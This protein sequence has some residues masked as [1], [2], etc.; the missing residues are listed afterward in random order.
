M[1]T[2]NQLVPVQTWLNLETG[3][4]VHQTLAPAEA[5]PAECGFSLSSS[6]VERPVLKVRRLH[7]EA[8]VPSRANPTD[9]GLDL[10]AVEDVTLAPAITPKSLTWVTNEKWPEPWDDLE[11]TRAIVRT[12]IAVEF[13]PGLALLIWDRSGMGAKGIH[14]LAGV[15]DSAYR[16]ELK[17]VLV[18]HSP[19]PY[20][21][22]KGDRIA[23]AIIQPV[24]LPTVV[25][26]ENLSDS[27]RGV[28]GFGSTGA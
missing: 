25:E 20:T 6:S 26:V 24:I 9:A 23:Q 8:R 16:G 21:I 18:N 12:G 2:M 17:V 11:P 22:K 19:A 15:I 1:E 13:P 10:Y 28:A 14:R 3:Q 7:P 27:E 4:L 5:L